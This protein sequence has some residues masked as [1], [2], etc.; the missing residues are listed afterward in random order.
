V[1]YGFRGRSY[2]P[3]NVVRQAVIEGDTYT[4]LSEK[5]KKGRVMR[6]IWVEKD[7]ALGRTASYTMQFF[8]DDSARMIDH[9][10][11]DIFRQ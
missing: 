5:I 2:K 10:S 8:L 6:V 9:V 11:K 4:R 3:D 1:N 7:G